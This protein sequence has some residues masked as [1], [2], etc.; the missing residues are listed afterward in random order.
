METH[1]KVRALYCIGQT[2]SEYVLERRGRQRH[3]GYAQHKRRVVQAHRA[4]NTS[5]SRVLPTEESARTGK[6]SD[7]KTE[8]VEA[9]EQVR[10]V[11]KEEWVCQCM[12][13]HEHIYHRML[14]QTQ[15]RANHVHLRAKVG[16]VHFGH[17]P[18]YH[19]FMENYV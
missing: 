18:H 12:Y 5:S 1:V 19:A 16:K 14:P 15:F 3:I 9:G 2:R 7:R 17:L 11:L 13:C 4:Q 6:V 8:C 10:Q